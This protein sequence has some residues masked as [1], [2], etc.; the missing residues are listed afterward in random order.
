MPNIHHAVL[1]AAPAEK[2]YNAITTEE[3]LS[4]WWTPGT[5]TKAEPNSIA[6]FP[7]GEQ[8]FKEMK[9]TELKP[10]ER[11]E[12]TCIA[13]ADEW[14]GTDISF[15]LTPGD[16]R[17]LLN[18]HPEMSGQLEQLKANKGTLL[19]FHHNNWKE[20]TLMYAE[21]NYTWG[22]FLKSLKLFCETGRGRP[23]PYQHSVETE[24]Q[25]MM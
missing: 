10:Y 6:R 13:G 23:W 22:Q 15:Q 5:T 3:G 8:Y 24:V 2:I 19:I 16:K 18:D 21:C 20:Y 12:W 4:S 14:I 7:F 25:F 1:I 9:I 17:T 11:V